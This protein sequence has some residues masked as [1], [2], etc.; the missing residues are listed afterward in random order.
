M[1]AARTKDVVMIG[2]PNGAGKTSWAYSQLPSTLEVREFVNADE[3]ARGFFPLDPEGSALAA[4]RLMIER[5]QA[6]IHSGESFAFE[7]TCAGRGHARLL[8]D[9]RAAGYR[10]TLV[11]LWLPS[12]DIA[13]ARVA[14]R[15]SEGGHRIPNDVIVRRYSIGIRNM[16]RIYLPLADIALIYDNSDRKGVLIASRRLNSPLVVHEANRWSKIEE[17]SR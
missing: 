7:T 9:C 14:Q 1:Q 12:A 17:T 15:V 11:F 16:V 8:Q 3:I 6:L 5:L 10:I 4:G 13:L 2:G